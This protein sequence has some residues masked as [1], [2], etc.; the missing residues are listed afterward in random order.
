MRAD[1]RL[2]RAQ[3]SMFEFHLSRALKHLQRRSVTR[4]YQMIFFHFRKTEPKV[5]PQMTENVQSIKK[6]SETSEKL[7]KDHQPSKKI[8]L[9]FRVG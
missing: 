5:V 1:G 6:T 8:I 2:H 7:K 4:E 9:N 3:L